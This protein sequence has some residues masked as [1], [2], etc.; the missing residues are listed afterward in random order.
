[1]T[2]MIESR[3]GFGGADGLE[4]DLPHEGSDR[5]KLTL[6]LTIAGTEHKVPGGQVKSLDLELRSWGFSGR[7]EFVLLDDKEKGG[8]T[9]DELYDDFIKKDLITI[10]L[11]VRAIYPDN[12]ID[13]AATPL[14]LTG[15]VT[16]KA[17]SDI[18]FE[19][20]TGGGV[21]AR[22]YYVRFV[23]AA[24]HL[25]RQHFPCELYVQKTLVDVLNAQKPSQVT[26]DYQWSDLNETAP[27]LFLGHEPG[28]GNASFYDFLIWYVDTR[29]GAFWF[30]YQK[31]GFVL[32]ADKPASSRTVK[33]YPDDVGRFRLIFP[34]A[35]RHKVRI[36]NSYTES[37]QTK[38]VEQEDKEGLIR[39]DYL[40]ATPVA[41]QV[42]ARA[43]L[44]KARLIARQNELSIGLARFPG[45]P[46]AP[47]DFIAF[48]SS[49]A[50]TKVGKPLPKPVQTQTMRVFAFDLRARAVDDTI[51][52][53]AGV[54][55]AGF[56]TQTLLRLELK[57]EKHVKLPPYIRPHYPRYIEGKIVSEV[58]ETEDLTY[59]IYTDSKTSIEQYKV[60][61][62]LFA[63]QEIFVPF[64]P[65]LFPGHYFFPAYKGQR[66]LIAF[67][68]ESAWLKRFLDWRAEGRLAGDTQGNHMLVGKKPSSSTSVKHVYGEDKPEFQILRTNEKDTQ[69]IHIK[70]GYMLIEV[71]EKK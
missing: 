55:D 17:Y 66:V 21:L 61:I 68:F 25:W 43:T 31:Q 53:R 14:A 63:N 54:D 70:E 18:V 11:S 23:D 67:D 9:K 58:G 42:D 4:F 15:L 30:D 28:A 24:Q 33:L 19:S 1:M 50:F 34:E 36:H 64:N 32:A 56:R 51:D 69:T 16:D 27:L 3:A 35:V 48:T 5:L 20:V 60:K 40:L 10:K 49:D 44:E 29:G 71:K 52:A 45:D 39:Q 13:T 6:S 8:K 41:A 12:K 47:G 26:I 2:A 46:I 57:A 37:A 65:N 59:Q 62:P 22:R 38:E 7:V